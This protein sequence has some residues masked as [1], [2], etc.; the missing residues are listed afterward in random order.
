MK[1]GLT[2]VSD[3]N[4]RMT[5]VKPSFDDG[6]IAYVPGVEVRSI[7]EQESRNF[8]DAILYGKE[9][10]VKPEQALV[11]TQILEAIYESAKT[12]KPVYFD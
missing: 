4:G 3:S 10:C 2:I 1:N 11:V 12:G 8:Y 7:Q 9:L 5:N 6:A